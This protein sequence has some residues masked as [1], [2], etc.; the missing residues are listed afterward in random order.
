MLP[1]WDSEAS[2][3]A[4]RMFLSPQC[5]LCSN[6]VT[7]FTG[8]FNSP[9]GLSTVHRVFQQSSSS[10]IVHR[11]FYFIVSLSTVHR[12]LQQSTRPST[13]NKVFQKYTGSS[14][15]FHRVS[16]KHL[17]LRVFQQSI[18]FFKCPF[19]TI[20]RVKPKLKRSWKNEFTSVSWKICY[21]QTIFFLTVVHP[22]FS[23]VVESN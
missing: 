15:S 1:F 16:L 6:H 19:L 7:T 11:V 3:Y 9:Q 8:S 20:H 17:V 5:P 2:Q 13:H 18:R 23:L 14:N 12:V 10:L 22:F 21:F 4:C